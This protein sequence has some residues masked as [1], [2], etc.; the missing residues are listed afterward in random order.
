[1]SRLWS[2]SRPYLPSYALGLLLL[3][4]TNG[5]SLWIPWLLR[6][7]IDAMESGAE[8]SVLGGFAL[9]MM[10]VALL[11]AI[12]RTLSRLV[13]LGNSRKIV[14]NVRNQFYGQLQ[15]LGAS[16]YD[17]HR[18][19]DIMSRGVNDI[20][21]LQGFY[22][23]GVMNLLNTTI[24]YVA[25]VSLLVSLNFKLTLVSLVLFPVLLLIVNRLSKRVY[26]V[27]MAVQTQ[28]AEISNRAQEN[29]SGIQ[30]V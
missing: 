2:F 30:Q 21:L 28:L 18:T 6:D 27:S 23:P 3:L 14:Y 29:L 13:I 7:A 11:Q 10:G 15:R 17:T 9:G 20:Q 22:C 8:L 25:V 5:L 4:A 26:G 16:Y 12:A 19:G 1:M 24:V